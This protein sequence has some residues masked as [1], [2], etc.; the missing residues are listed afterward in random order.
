MV[1][2]VAVVIASPI[3]LTPL[4]AGLASGHSAEKMSL[5]ILCNHD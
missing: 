5:N 1:V 2:S 3:S 4:M